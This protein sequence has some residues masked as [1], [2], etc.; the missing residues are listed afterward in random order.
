[1]DRAEFLALI[2]ELI[3]D[4]EHL[5]GI[6]DVVPGPGLR[7]TMKSGEEFILTAVEA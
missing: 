3:L 5:E 1:M 6:T 7:V 4:S 2:Y